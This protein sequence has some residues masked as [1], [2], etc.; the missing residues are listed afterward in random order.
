MSINRP[1]AF[2]GTPEEAEANL[3]SHQWIFDEPGES[4]VCAL[5]SH[6]SWHIG[7]KYPCGVEPPRETVFRLDDGT[8]IVTRDEYG[9]EPF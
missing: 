2:P 7:A 9:K 8:E 6:K 5:C 4:P 3:R 1:V